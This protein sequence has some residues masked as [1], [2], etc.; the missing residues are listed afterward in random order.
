LPFALC[1]SRV[2]HSFQ[3]APRP[4]SQSRLFNAGISLS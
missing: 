1:A 2:P 3:I 4:A